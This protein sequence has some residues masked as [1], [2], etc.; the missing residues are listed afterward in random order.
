PLDL[1]TRFSANEIDGDCQRGSPVC[2]T[3]ISELLEVLERH[4]LGLVN[5]L[6]RDENGGKWEGRD[7]LQ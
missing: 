1:V 6:P 7:D 5:D 3:C 2:Q 4:V